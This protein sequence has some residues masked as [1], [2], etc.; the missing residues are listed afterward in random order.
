MIFID[1][2]FLIA[3]FVDK[4]QWHKKGIRLIDK[5]DKIPKEDKIISNLVIEEI[6]TLIGS[7]IG[8]KASIEVYGYIHDNYTVFNEDK[9][10]YDKSMSSFLKYNAT[11]SLTDCVSVEIMKELEINE[12]VSFDSDFDKVDGIVRVH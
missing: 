12:I 7:K 10:L 11:L 8:A 9:S 5:I 6:I 1:S 3:I 4:D 2:G